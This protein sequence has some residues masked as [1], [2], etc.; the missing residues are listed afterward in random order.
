MVIF[1]LDP[2]DHSGE[3]GPLGKGAY[4]SHAELA[5]MGQ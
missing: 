4:G 5:L 2:R 1:P 3:H